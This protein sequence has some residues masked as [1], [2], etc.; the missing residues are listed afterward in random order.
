MAG[1]FYPQLPE[2]TGT[3]PPLARRSSLLSLTLHNQSLPNPHP[4][5]STLTLTT[6]TTTTT[7]NAICPTQPGPVPDLNTC[8]SHTHTLGS[9]L[10]VLC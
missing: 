5:A 3:F 9:A 4:D 8:L 1:D 10:G 6:I 2:N 7:Y